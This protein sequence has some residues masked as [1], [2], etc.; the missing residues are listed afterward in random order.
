MTSPLEPRRTAS[1]TAIVLTMAGTVFLLAMAQ[2]LPVPALP[3]IGLQ[4]VSSRR[5]PSAG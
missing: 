4:L 1:P 5:P 3:Q 2:T